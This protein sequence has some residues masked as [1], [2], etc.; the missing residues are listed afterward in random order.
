METIQPYIFGKVLRKK[1]AV[2]KRDKT[3]VT[4]VDRLSRH[5]AR[6]ILLALK[7]MG[8][9]MIAEDGERSQR[10]MRRWK[11]EG[12]QRA[13]EKESRWLTNILR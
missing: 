8:F 9:Q 2:T 5:N 10:W 1:R 7:A 13:E 12:M 3:Y 11:Q 6:Q 4:E